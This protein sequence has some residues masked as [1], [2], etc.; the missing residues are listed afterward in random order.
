VRDVDDVHRDLAAP[1]VAGD[2]AVDA[3]VIGGR[4]HDRR[5]LEVILFVALAANLDHAVLCP[6][7]DLFG[8]VRR[9]DGDAR[10]V[11]Q[12]RLGFARADITAADDQNIA[13]FDVEVNGVVG[14]LFLHDP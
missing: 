4:D 2:A 11:L 6:L 3:L 1:A 9:D 8:E 14:I 5:A 7:L 13:L 10:A 12:H